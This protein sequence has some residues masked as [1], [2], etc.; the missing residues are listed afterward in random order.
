MYRG[1]MSD[2]FQPR[3]TNEMVQAQ[4]ASVLAAGTA[5]VDAWLFATGC[6]A[7]IIV[8]VCVGSP[9]GLSR[10]DGVDAWAWLAPEFPDHGN[11]TVWWVMRSA[12]EGEE[13]TSPLVIMSTPPIQ[14]QANLKHARNDLISDMYGAV[15]THWE[16]NVLIFKVD[17]GDHR[18]LVSVEIA[19]LPNIWACI[20]R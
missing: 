10:W 13:M 12:V 15:S 5:T 19:D 9:D 17:P 1:M 20:R 3:V 2:S 11:P 6:P 16:G 8:P 14:S 4:K 18:H 7:P